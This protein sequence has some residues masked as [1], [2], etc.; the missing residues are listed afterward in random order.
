MQFHGPTH[1][2]A[3]LTNTQPVERFIFMLGSALSS[4]DGP[5]SPGV[6]RVD[7]VVEQA[8]AILDSLQKAQLK[9]KL[10]KTPRNRYETAMAYIHERKGRD[11]ANQIIQDAVFKALKKKGMVGP[12][13]MDDEDWPRVPVEEMLD[14]W[15]IPR[16]L[17]AFG[18]LA[19]YFG[20]RFAETI[21]TTN[22]DPL[23]G[24][25][26]RNAGGHYFRINIPDDGDLRAMEGSVP[27]IVHL[28]GYWHNS[29]TLHTSTQ[30]ADERPYL[31]ESLKMLLIKRT[32][33]VIGYGGWDDVLMRA[34]ADI[35]IEP[36]CG[37]RIVWC[38]WE[39]D[40]AEI[41]RNYKHILGILA[42]AYA[43][44]RLTIITGFD[45]NK[46]LPSLWS[47]L[48][49]QELILRDCLFRFLESR[50]RPGDPKYKSFSQIVLPGLGYASMEELVT[51]HWK[52]PISKTDKLAKA[53]TEEG[54][55]DSREI[56]R[57][58]FN[59]WLKALY[60]DSA[61]LDLS[62]EDTG[63]SLEDT[64]SSIE[65]TNKSKRKKVRQSR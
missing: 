55:S 30:L 2:E 39:S 50:I 23:T 52:L 35:A 24:I 57:Y 16:G 60:G 31:Q 43:Q 12:L 62:L 7:G 41:Q 19:A 48:A 33:V 59:Y 44:E 13:D 63:I 36:R 5:K 4:P 8:L 14:M 38:F 26:I 40:V 65:D 11:A 29:D 27:R 51:E 22:F 10:S 45:V 37:T 56:A 17:G 1:L 21:L 42:P 47:T 34:L 54:V 9:N 64:G 18:K 28:H 53:F 20:R 25:A 58:I 61:R 49:G 3:L 15:H 32:L 46:H 6:P